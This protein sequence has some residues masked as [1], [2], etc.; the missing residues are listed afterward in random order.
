M[1]EVSTTMRSWHASEKMLKDPETEAHRSCRVVPD[2][3]APSA[4]ESLFTHTPGFIPASGRSMKPVDVNTLALLQGKT[5]DGQILEEGITERA[6]WPRLLRRTAYATHGINDSILIYYRCSGSA[7]C[8]FILGRGGHRTRG[9]CRGTRTH[10]L[11]GRRSA[12]QDGNSHVLACLFN[13]KAY[14][15]RSPMKSR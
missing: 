3:P 7:Y 10:N 1:A 11:F 8:G 2:E 13:N 4:I 12:H 14:D 9:S 15:R 5:K 6:P